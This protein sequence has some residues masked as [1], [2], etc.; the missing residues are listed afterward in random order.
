MRTATIT[1]NGKEHLLCFSA[2]V[3]RA[4]TERYGD[5]SGLGDALDDPDK[6]KALDEAVWILA[7]MMDAGARYAKLNGLDNP[8]PL[9][10]DQIYDTSDLGDFFAIRKR[11]VD[12]V[13]QGR[14]THVEVEPPKNGE[15]TQGAR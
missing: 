11:V 13:T 5:V 14:A 9:S 7:Q 4:C 15:A 3:I 6:G 10:A 8:E 2:R 12:T 1:I